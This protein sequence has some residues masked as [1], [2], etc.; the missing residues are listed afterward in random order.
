M[1]L[2]TQIIHILRNKPDAACRMRDRFRRS[3]RNEFREWSRRLRRVFPSYFANELPERSVF[4][5]LFHK[6][7]SSP[8]P[9]VSFFLSL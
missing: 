3:E 1:Q 2:T 5:K 9:T 4:A 8:P 7:C 6:F